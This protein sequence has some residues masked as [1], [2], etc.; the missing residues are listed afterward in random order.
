MIE[1]LTGQTADADFN[2]WELVLLNPPGALEG[3][4]LVL[5]VLFA[6][7]MFSRNLRREKSRGWKIFMYGLRSALLLGLILLWLQPAVQLQKLLNF[8]S[9][10]PI[11]I[12][13]SHSMALPEEVD[14]RMR[15]DAV[16]EFLKDNRDWLASLAEKHHLHFYSFDEKPLLTSLENL[17]KGEAPEGEY[18]DISGS[19]ESVLADYNSGEVAGALL[20][21]DGVEIKPGS[22]DADSSA[23][24]RRLAEQKLPLYT[25]GVGGDKPLP[26]V[27]V[28]D[29]L[30]DGFAF[31]HNKISIEVRVSS[32]GFAS[33][34]TDARLTVEGKPLQ[35]QPVEL[36]KDGEV[37]LV[38]TFTPD[39]VGRRIYRVSVPAP[40]GDAV[41]GNNTRSFIVNVLRDKIRV[42]HVCGHPDYDE[43][44][45]RQHLKRNPSIDLISFF[46]LRTYDDLQYVP[47]NELSLIQF[48]TLQLFDEELHTFDLVIFQN[49]TYKGYEMEQYLNN[50]R[51]YVQGGGGFLMIGG[52]LSFGLGRYIGTP[53]AEALPVEIFPDDPG[54]DERPF[55]LRP[56][57]E[58]L[59]HPVMQFTR[60]PESDRAIWNDLPELLGLNLGLLSRAD[61]VVLAEH[62]KL[63]QG[64]K[65]APL[66]VA[67]SYGKG[68]A[69]AFAAD[70]SWTW[71]FVNSGKG[72]DARY[73]GAFWNNAIRWLIHD[74]EL[75]YLKIS[76]S[77]EE[78]APG[79]KLRLAL[80]ASDKNFQPRA[81]T[82]LIVTGSS[83]DGNEIL[84]EEVT[85]GED[86]RANLQVNAPAAE[87]L[88][89]LRVE[90]P[91]E[92]GLED[93]EAPVFVHSS[94]RE[95]EEVGVDF[96]YLKTAAKESGGE[97]FKLPLKMEADDLDLARG[98][99]IRIGKK[100][101]IPLWDSSFVLFTLVLLAA[102]EW[103]W[104][105][106]R[107][108]S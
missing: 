65:P 23:L 38:F 58:G 59:Q 77:K 4:L 34:K 81:D 31:V 69:L 82:R 14:G 49:F 71:N 98:K 99:S 66:L 17:E 96:E 92:P 26:D 48:P 43:Q 36:P 19:L 40:S 11:L 54:F 75:R 78:C 85:T 97:F 12:D 28:R 1:W 2:N 60:S 88:F 89:V 100:K 53:V 30:Y 79:E 3:V 35:V 20:F 61:A 86:G 105:R 13:R 45:L 94:G 27:A 68:R 32:R 91:D 33:S 21:S 67:G 5:V 42:L 7:Y 15:Y 37:R 62:P 18:S 107:R 46:I 10:L 51:S 8:K 72:K 95:L 70:S 6:L 57:E 52:D 29:V 90:A 24:W 16:R 41:P 74:P 102:L 55:K 63:R 101:D 87:G 83:S 56:T 76:S 103:W 80:E 25:F 47:E 84:R 50:I 9:H 39:K 22:S 44:F 93:A 106:R 64:G 73:Y 104:R 108:L